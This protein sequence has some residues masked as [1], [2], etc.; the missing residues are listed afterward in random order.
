[1]LINELMSAPLPNNTRMCKQPNQNLQLNQTFRTCM[2]SH[3]KQKISRRTTRLITGAL[4]LSLLTLTTPLILIRI[5][6]FWS[7]C[8]LLSL[9]TCMPITRLTT[10][11]PKIT[12]PQVNLPQVLETYRNI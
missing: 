8:A 12:A 1:M 3:P 9:S 7:S 5:A 4:K 11:A 6:H 10:G 2:H